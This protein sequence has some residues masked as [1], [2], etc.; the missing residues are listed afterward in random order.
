MDGDFLCE[1]AWPLKYSAMYIWLGLLGVIRGVCRIE[2]EHP[3]FAYT[4]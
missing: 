1:H 2:L 4:C 3:V